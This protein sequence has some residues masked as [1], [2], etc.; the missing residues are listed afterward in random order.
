MARRF[1][2]WLSPAGVVISYLLA[3]F[4]TTAGVVCF[5]FSMVSL[6]LL[7]VVV[8][9]FFVVAIL[10]IVFTY[11]T[12]SISLTRA[13]FALARRLVGSNPNPGL[14]DKVQPKSSA[15]RFSRQASSVGLWD[16][17]MDGV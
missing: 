9:P 15:K 4:A 17:W 14:C 7:F 11:V 5:P 12:L 6:A 3:L 13:I 16:R 1:A 2:F 10:V 8:G